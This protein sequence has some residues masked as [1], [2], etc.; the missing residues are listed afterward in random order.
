[1]S[2]DRLKNSDTTSC[3]KNNSTNSR[4]P[5]IE[6]A[7]ASDTHE[8]PANNCSQDSS[9]VHA[10]NESEDVGGF[11]ARASHLLNVWITEMRGREP[12]A[13]GMRYR[14]IKVLAF[15]STSY[16]HLLE[17]FAKYIWSVFCSTA[18]ANTIGGEVLN[19]V[20]YVADAAY[21]CG[22]VSKIP[23]VL[24]SRSESG[25]DSTFREVYGL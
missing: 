1:M 24:M 16:A 4:P 23:I 14:A 17:Y 20:P 3:Q 13:L 5:E 10:N 19:C 25:S 2:G 18:G 9:A 15:H 21:A 12:S 11:Q 22:M 6:S 8:H 7:P